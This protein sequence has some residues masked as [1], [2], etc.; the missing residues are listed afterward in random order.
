LETFEEDEHH[1]FNNTA[2]T[3]NVSGIY[4]WVNKIYTA[5]VF[6][7]GKR[8][9]IDI[10][11]PEP[12][13]LLLDAANITLQTGTPQPPPP[14]T[15]RPADLIYEDPT[16]PMYYGNYLALY[17]VE[18]LDPPP[19]D[20]ISLTQTFT[21]NKDNKTLDQ[22]VGM[23]IPDGYE[24]VRVYANLSYNFLN[25]NDTLMAVFVGDIKF[26]WK[27]SVQNLPVDPLTNNPVTNEY[28]MLG[29][30]CAK[31]IGVAVFAPPEDG[32]GDYAVMVEI[33]CSPTQSSIATWQLKTHSKILGAY[34]QKLRDYQD[35]LT[36]RKMNPPTTGPLG[37]NNPDMNLITVR[38]ELQRGA[39]QLITQLDLMEFKD[40]I[41]A[42]PT[43][44]PSPGDPPSQLF[45]RPNY[46]PAVQDGA[47][48]RFFEQAFEWEQMQYVFYPYYWSRKDVWYDKLM[49]TNDDPLFAEFLKA[50]QARAVIPVRPSM[51]PS[52][53]YYLMTG[54]TWMGGDPPTV[55]DSDY[56]SIVD[57]IK[58][59][60]EA[61]GDEV[62][63]G[64]SW[65]VSV[66]TTLIK[67]R[68]GDSI[69]NVKWDL[70]Q[71]WTWTAEPDGSDNP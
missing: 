28:A 35:A 6:N 14:F 65:E 20:N 9:L 1:S 36:S 69:D 58:E 52:V 42:T 18:G 25:D 47:F 37:S 31:N 27:N 43:G 64:P 67:L 24:A 46:S 38:T 16:D 34:N 4:Q 3:E 68:K 10:M 15:A 55:T 45:P 29:T 50:G 39:I 51:E 7:Y 21:L 8:L 44:S 11:V 70:E 2:G 62:P 48:A 56:L 41:V 59:Q 30:R 23:K 71:P 53:W 19:L 17:D 54:Q 57:E 33:D 49:R 40:V 63:Y 5:Q 61:P 66:P 26:Q 12:A 32:I 22:S 13:A 60:T